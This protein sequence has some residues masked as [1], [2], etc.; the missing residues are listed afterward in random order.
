M[1]LFFALFI[2]C[3][4][5]LGFSVA[6]ASAAFDAYS[7]EGQILAEATCTAMNPRGGWT[8]AV[9]RR[10][11]SEVVDC[12]SLCRQLTDSQAGRLAAFNS[13]HIYGNDPFGGTSQTGLKTY[14]YNT[15]NAGG[16]GP[17]YCCCSGPN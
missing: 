15:I 4:F 1:H 10:C 17:N 2:S 6:P 11:S 3:V 13:L 8:F 14:K 12:E 9:G 16:C 5:L 7:V